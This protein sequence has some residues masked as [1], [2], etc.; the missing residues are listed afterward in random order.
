MKA[1]IS[2]ELPK[3]KLSKFN[4]PRVQKALTQCLQC[5]YC[6][7]VCEAHNQTPWESVT[8][9]GKIYYIKAIDTNGMD[10]VDTALGRKIELSDDFVDA[11]YKCTGCGNCEVVCH[12]HISLVDLWEE[13]REWM[14][15]NGAGPLPAHKGIA[16]NVKN[17]HNSFGESPA[18]RDA[19][20]PADIERAAVPD[21]IFFAGCT[22]SYRMQH[23]PTAGVT[24]LSRAGVKMNCLGEKEYCCSSPLLRTGNSNLSLECAEAVVEKADGMGAKDMVM[25]CSGCYKT[26]SSDFGKYYS[27]VGQNVYHFSQYVEKLI[28]ERKLPLNNEFNAKV[29]YHDPCHLGRHSGVYDAPRN[30][31]K[32]I[33]GVEFVEME[34]SRENSRCCGAGGGYKSAFGDLATNIAAERIRDAEATGAEILVTC[35][36]FCVLNL[37]QG[38]KKAGSN[39]KVMDLSQVLLQV[40]APKEAAPKE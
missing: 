32:K 35:C 30:V 12:A 28:N 37:T 4:L 7:E 26:V 29:T 39:I 20:W 18:K 13:M 24:V 11:M 40:T 8:P 21:A 5:G 36:P 2:V 10:I 27:K 16:V 38:A 22:G 25:T 1:K 9:R 6:I 14:F 3:V 23:V 17:K 15:K 33:K 19:W 34:K 31:L